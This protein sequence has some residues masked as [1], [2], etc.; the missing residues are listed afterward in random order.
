[1]PPKKT[2]S[3]RRAF[4]RTSTSRTH[5]PTAITDMSRITLWRALDWIGSS[6]SIVGDRHRGHSPAPAL[7]VTW[8]GPRIREIV[9][10]THGVET[11]WGRGRRDLRPRRQRPACAAVNDLRRAFASTSVPWLRALFGCLRCHPHDRAPLRSARTSRRFVS[12]R[13]WQ[14]IEKP[15]AR[16]CSFIFVSRRPRRTR[17]LTMTHPP[18]SP[19]STPSRAAA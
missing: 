17:L 19:H 15:R 3:R 2:D 13:R 11:V 9:H 12:H 18:T 6:G 4:S 14:S 16:W 10:E 8:M 5:S 7:I 1:M